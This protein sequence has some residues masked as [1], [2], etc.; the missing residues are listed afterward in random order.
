[1]LEAAD[2][3]TQTAKKKLAF[4]GQWWIRQQR[5]KRSQNT[6]GDFYAAS[7]FSGDCLKL[8]CQSKRV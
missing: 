2:G 6:W 5:I 1:M 3:R 4:C 7:F 8:N